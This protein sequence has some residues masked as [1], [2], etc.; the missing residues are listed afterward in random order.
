MVRPGALHGVIDRPELPAGRQLLDA[1]LPVGAGAERGSVLEQRPDQAHDQLARRLNVIGDVGGADQRLH[2]VREDGGLV[3]ALGELFALSE[4][5]VVTKTDAAADAREG[6]GADDGG[7]ALGQVPFGQRGV[8]TVQRVGDREPQNG[9]AQELEP[10]VGGNAAV[11]VGVGTVCER[12][13]KRPGV[14]SDTE[15]LQKLFS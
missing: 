2:G 11:F 13:T 9:V 7:T 14:N 6:P 10:F 4:V 12:K 5:D 1:R 8:V 3:F 15:T